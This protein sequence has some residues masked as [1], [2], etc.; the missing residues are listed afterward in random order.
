LGF[1]GEDVSA[2]LFDGLLWFILTHILTKFKSFKVVYNFLHQ[3]LNPFPRLTAYL[4]IDA[5]SL[6]CHV[7]E[8]G[9]NFFI[10]SL[11]SDDIYGA[12]SVVV[13]DLPEPVVYT[14]D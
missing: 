13:F 11:V 8:V 4:H 1:E 7:S 14:I 3:T 5:L 6:S 2:V 10:I 12:G 9:T